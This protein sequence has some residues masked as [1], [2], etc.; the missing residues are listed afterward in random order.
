[1]LQVTY[2]FT[3]HLER[4]DVRKVEKLGQPKIAKLTMV[5]QSRTTSC[6]AAEHL[7]HSESL[8]PVSLIPINH[9][10]H[11]IFTTRGQKLSILCIKH[12]AQMYKITHTL[13]SNS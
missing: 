8:L 12:I 1:M 9:P 5:S 11:F 6:V 7:L 10:V 3:A 4:L 2:D 13:S